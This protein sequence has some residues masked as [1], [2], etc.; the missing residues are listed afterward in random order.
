LQLDAHT[1]LRQDFHGD[2]MSHACVM[3]RVYDMGIPFKQYGIRSGTKEEY[4]FMKENDTLLYDFSKLE[5]YIHY[6]KQNNFP[7]YITLDLDI[8]DPSIF[9]GTGTPEPG[10]IDFNHLMKIIKMLQ[11]CNI[12]SFDIVE[13][14]P[15][16]DLSG[17]STVVAYKILREMMLLSF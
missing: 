8:L 11:G 4:E 2:T 10:G 14:S 12:V 7:L 17:V 15:Y 1:D 5:V 16:Y 13:L 3:R 9:P 6:L